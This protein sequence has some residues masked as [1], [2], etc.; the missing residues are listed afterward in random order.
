MLNTL[1]PKEFLECAGG[2]RWAAV[3]TEFLWGTI[4]LEQL[5]TDGHQYGCSGVTWF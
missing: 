3:G 4:C 5:L 2:G 1:C